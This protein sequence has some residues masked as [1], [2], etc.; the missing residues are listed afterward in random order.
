MS[1][2][3]LHDPR[4][5]VSPLHSGTPRVLAWRSALVGL[6]VA[7]GIFL[8]H[9]VNGTFDCFSNMGDEGMEV[10]KAVL[11]AAG[12]RL[13][14]EVWNDQPPLYTHLLS[15][16]CRRQGVT[17]S[18]L[19]RATFVFVAILLVAFA[20]VGGS[21]RLSLGE[22]VCAGGFLAASPVFLPSSASTTLELPAL[23][24]GLLG[25]WM[26]L[27]ALGRDSTAWAVA[28]G[29]VLGLGVMVKLTAFSVLPLVAG[30]FWVSG[31]VVP[32]RRL[33]LAGGALVACLLTAAAVWRACAG[34]ASWR[35]L[36]NTHFAEYPAL[37]SEDA[38]SYRFRWDWFAAE[39]WLVGAALVGVAVLA[40]GAGTN[41]PIFRRTG[42]MASPSQTF[43]VLD[44]DQR[45]IN[46][47]YFAVDL[48]NTGN[49]DGQGAAIPLAII[50]FPGQRHTRAA[51]VAFGDGHVEVVRWK[52]ALLS[53]RSLFPG[54]RVDPASHDGRWL[55][56]HVVG[57]P[58]SEP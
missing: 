58:A 28:G 55:H 9:E 41:Y 8:W 14:T 38:A 44:E 18:S 40:G 2:E 10:N 16:P 46:D 47:G 32:K 30:A 56:E 54:L 20:G 15:I 19:R 12:H 27:V 11:V 57:K 35:H 21:L 42:E 22:L 3:L 50:D 5:E 1:A 52:D 4:A 24:L 6:V 34:E 37:D 31:A 45:Q 36:V 51:T 26:L 13:Y 49:P 7:L 33:L 43:T 23:S 48:S 29:V 25:A 17:M 53:A 39:P